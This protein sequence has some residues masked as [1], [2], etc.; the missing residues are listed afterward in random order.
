[1]SVGAGKPLLAN[2]AINESMPGPLTTMNSFCIPCGIRLAPAV[3]RR[4]SQ[5]KSTVVQTAERGEDVARAL[6]GEA[7][8]HGSTVIVS[9]ENYAWCPGG[10]GA[11]VFV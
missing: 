9:V 10:G 11:P 3:T 4:M 1:M 5:A 6:T 2:P 8:E 7:V